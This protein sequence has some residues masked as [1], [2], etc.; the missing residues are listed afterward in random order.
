MN[1]NRWSIITTYSFCHQAYQSEPSGECD[2]LQL[3]QKAQHIQS[4]T[5]CLPPVK[6]TGTI[7]YWQ[8]QQNSAVIVRTGNSP[9]AEKS[10]AIADAGKH[11][12]I[13]R[14]ERAHYKI[15]CAERKEILHTHFVTSGKFTPPPPLLSCILCNSRTL[16]CTT[17][18]LCIA[19]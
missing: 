10:A 2:M 3:K 6:N 18:L 16:K 5:P 1:I 8:C 15:T 11:L 12:H 13:V 4:P 17:P 9:E 7:Y 14:M 19:S